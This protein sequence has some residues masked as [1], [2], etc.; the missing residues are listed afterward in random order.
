VLPGG[1]AWMERRARARVYKVVRA[2]NGRVLPSAAAA[3]WMAC[4][5]CPGPML[6]PPVSAAAS[7]PAAPSV[8][9]HV[10]A[11][12]ILVESHVAADELE[13]CRAE[14]DGF[15]VPCIAVSNPKDPDLASA[16]VTPGGATSASMKI[17]WE[18]AFIL[19]GVPVARQRALRFTGHS[20]RHFLPCL[21]EV[22]MWQHALRDEVGTW[23]TGAANAKRLKCGP[24]Y[25]VAR[26]RALQVFLRRRLR[27]AGVDVLQ[28][29]TLGSGDERILP[30]FHDLAS[31]PVIQRSDQFG[32]PSFVPGFGAVR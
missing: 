3:W 17:M 13:T 23:A 24:R 22:L 1:F 8:L 19:V 10:R 7:G 20:A 6:P 2:P 4:E 9:S 16:E 25:T 32:G 27:L 15:L 12:R 21:A 31:S 11:A 18:L 14:H 5:G 30:N 26:N 28:E 29:A